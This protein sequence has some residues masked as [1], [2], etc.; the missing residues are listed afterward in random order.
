MSTQVETLLT[1][2][3]V[4]SFNSNQNRLPCL[5]H[6]L[7][8]AIIDVMNV[9]TRIATV[10]TTIA[11][12]EYNLTLT[13]NHIMDNSLDVIAAM[14]TLAIKIQSSGLRIAYFEH[15]QKECGI[16][17]PL[18]IPLQNNVHWGTA[19]GMLGHSY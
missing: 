5:A 1:C 15:L 10:E 16:D 14:H 18:K 4:Y 3:H 19:D 6:I 13:N 2:R 12:W 11:I 17:V 9:I 7:N 8:L